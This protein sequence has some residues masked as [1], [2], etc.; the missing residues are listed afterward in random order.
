[1]PYLRIN[2][3]SF[4]DPYIMIEETNKLRTL[5]VGT[6]VHASI[7]IEP[8]ATVEMC[9]NFIGV[10]GRLTRGDIALTAGDTLDITWIEK[11]NDDFWE[12]MTA[13]ELLTKISMDI[14]LEL[15][16]MLEEYN[17]R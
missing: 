4:P 14:D 10:R 2:N 15:Q 3:I 1:M 16:K 7:Y 9:G 11:D 13:E 6:K 8:N 17:A 12:V 5:K